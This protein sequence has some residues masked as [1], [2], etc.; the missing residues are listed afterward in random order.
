MTHLRKQHQRDALLEWFKPHVS[1][2]IISVN[3]RV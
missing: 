2:S 1:A 3:V